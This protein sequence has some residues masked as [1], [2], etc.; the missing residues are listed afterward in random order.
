MKKIIVAIIIA[1]MLLSFATP[2]FAD[3]GS[4]GVEVT[5]SVDSGGGDIGLGVG[6]DS[7][8]GNIDVSINGEPLQGIVDTANQ[9]LFYSTVANGRGAWNG[10]DWY[11]AW[12][13][14]IKP[15]TDAINNQSGLLSML[16]EASAKLIKGQGLSQ[17]E[18]G[19]INVALQSLSNIFDASQKVMNITISDLKTQDDK[20]WNQLMYG[21]ET[22]I[23]ILQDVV[24]E[25]SNVMASMQSQLDTQKSALETVNSNYIDL[26]NYT[27][28]LQRQ[29]LY[30]FW[31][32]GGCV[33]V[34]FGLVVWAL[35][36]KRA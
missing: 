33:V 28:Y 34:L 22:Q 3:D 31:I 36:R 14:N 5:V 15:Y 6:L 35:T 7:G 25:Q 24:D 27:D 30:Y 10:R 16:T 19:N 8:G 2:I 23:S 13:K 18:L 20:T 12:Y 9:A 1:T 26:L 32:L 11:K 4:G 21:A 17:G 29:Y